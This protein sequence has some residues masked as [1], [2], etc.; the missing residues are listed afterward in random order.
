HENT[1]IVYLSAKRDSIFEIEKWETKNFLDWKIEAITKNSNKDNV[2]P[3]AV[4]NAKEGNPIQLLWMQN[5]KYI[6][7]TNYFSTIKMNKLED[8]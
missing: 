1:N 7:Y 4:K 3:V 2:R 8:K 5:N 6:H